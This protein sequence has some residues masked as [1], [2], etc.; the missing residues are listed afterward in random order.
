MAAAAGGSAPSISGLQLHSQDCGNLDV[1]PFLQQRRPH[2]RRERVDWGFLLVLSNVEATQRESALRGRASSTDP[3]GRFRCC[4]SEQL[5]WDDGPPVPL[6]YDT[7][8]V[9][10]GVKRTFA[11]PTQHFTKQTTNFASLLPAHKK[12]LPPLHQLPR[13]KLATRGSNTEC[14]KGSLHGL[15]E[16]GVDVTASNRP[17]SAG[18]RNKCDSRRQRVRF[19]ARRGFVFSLEITRT[20]SVLLV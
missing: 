18:G 13:E 2:R 6:K 8:S 15:V 3:T 16:H 5:R 19:A 14:R 10:T 17:S 4:C 12:L 20:A 11:G 9:G 1:A 7:L